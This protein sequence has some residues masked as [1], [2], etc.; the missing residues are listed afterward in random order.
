MPIMSN[1]PETSLR[2]RRRF[3]KYSGSLGASVF[4]SDWPAWAQDSQ[5]TLRFGIIADVHKDIMHDADE[6]L[7]AFIQHMKK[8]QVDFIVQLGDF[9]VPKEANKKFLNIWN[10]FSGPRF[11]VLG[12]HDTDG[13]YTREQTVAWWKMPSRYY[14]FEQSGVQFIVLDGN[15][16]PKNH[17][18][19]YPR[20]IEE[21]QLNWLRHQLEA[22]ELPIVVFVHQSLEREEKGGVQNGADVRQILEEANTK[23][24]RRRVVACFS[25]HHHRDYVRQI[26]D[27]VYPQ[28]NSASYHWVGADFQHV[29]YSESIDQTH[30]YIKYTVPY[31]DALFAIVTI[32][33]A[34]SFMSIDGKRSTFVG[35]APWEIE[36]D[37]N[38]WDAPTLTPHI[39]NWK[40]PV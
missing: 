17:S 12:N 21:D 16:R 29:R 33:R 22:S 13:G 28:I 3:L 11:H 2:N 26:N 23:A 36:H 6:R 38:Y 39:S 37:R 31:K 7:L 30:P 25:G 4:L 35:P 10:S 15:D 27:I 9:C 32:D 5:E 1:E 20:F 8:E 24:G 19:G 40:M 34:K 18:G 14:K